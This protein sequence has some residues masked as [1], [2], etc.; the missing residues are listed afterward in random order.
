LKRYD[1]SYKQ[2]GQPASYCL[3]AQGIRYL[4][5]L[6]SQYHNRSTLLDFYRNPSIS[7]EKI[8]AYSFVFDLFLILKKQTGQQFSVYTRYEFD[9]SLHPYP[10]PL[11]KLEDAHP[12]NNDFVLD[13]I[14]AYTP[15]WQIRRRIR[16]HEAKAEE[17]EYL[18][19]NILF[20]AGNESTEKRL[21]KLTNE[22]YNDF[23]YSLTQL[24]MLLSSKDGVVWI[25]MDASDDENFIR[26]T[27]K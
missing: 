25:D 3:S 24:S 13:F 23:D 6:D 5:Q 7:D 4:M 15:T 9:R 11:L 20:I 10:P 18:Y 2:I 26:T 12:D 17:S 8:S 27:L 16:Q 14:E 1:S 22:N 21:F 19:P